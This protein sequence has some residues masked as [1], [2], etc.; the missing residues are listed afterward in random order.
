MQLP[1]RIAVKLAGWRAA[2]YPHEQYP[3]IAEILDWLSGRD[4]VERFAPA[5][6]CFLRTL[7]SVSLL[8]DKVA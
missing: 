3:A 7:H 4:A 5:V 1:Q 6:T 8:T 2:G